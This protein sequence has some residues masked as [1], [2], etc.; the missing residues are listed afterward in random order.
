[1]AREEA[2]MDE[3]DMMEDLTL[4]SEVEGDLEEDY[5]YREVDEAEETSV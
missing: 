2:S 3:V 5:A 4:W 1:M